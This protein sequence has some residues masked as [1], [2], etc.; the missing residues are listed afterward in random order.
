MHSARTTRDYHGRPA[1]R[2][3]ILRDLPQDFIPDHDAQSM[4]QSMSGQPRTRR[5]S[6]G[7]HRA[8]FGII[9]VVL[10]PVVFEGA[11]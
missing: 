3:K 2:A 8:E 5:M 1:R 7:S 4:P 6:A 11:S 9:A 10:E